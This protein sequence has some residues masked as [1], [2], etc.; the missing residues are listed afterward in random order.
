MQIYFKNKLQKQIA[1]LMWAA[2]STNEVNVI[3]RAFG[4]DSETVYQMIVAEAIDEQ[5]NQDHSLIYAR[6]VLEQFTRN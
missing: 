3:R 2:H 1:Q 4:V 5:V 6:Q